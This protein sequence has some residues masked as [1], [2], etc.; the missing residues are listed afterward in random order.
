MKLVFALP[1][2]FADYSAG[3]LNIIGGDFLTLHFPV[4]PA[5]QM[6]FALIGRLQLEDEERGEFYQVRISVTSEAGE[7]IAPEGV[8]DIPSG[9][10]TK[11]IGEEYRTSGM[12]VNYQGLT[13]PEPGVYTFHILDGHLELG[14]L[15]ITVQLVDSANTLSA[16]SVSDVV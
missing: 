12:V 14:K 6:T 5:S 9:Q 10:F 1:A 8:M 7:P 11:R 15:S 13:F 2:I 3:K 16:T 4:F